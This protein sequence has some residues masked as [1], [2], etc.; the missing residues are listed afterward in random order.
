MGTK[1]NLWALGTFSLGSIWLMGANHHAFADDAV[2]QSVPITRKIG[3]PNL[4][5]RGVAHQNDT[6]PLPVSFVLSADPPDPGKDIADRPMRLAKLPGDRAASAAKSANLG[7]EMAATDESP[8]LRSP[9]AGPSLRETGRVGTTTVFDPGFWIQRTPDSVMPTEEAMQPTA[10]DVNRP[11]VDSRTGLLSQSV[12]AQQ[13]GKQVPTLNGC[14]L[15]VARQQRLPWNE[16]AAGRV[17]LQWNISPTGAVADETV[18]AV[19]PIDLHVLDCVR[20]K[21]RRWTFSRPSSGSIVHVVQPFVF[22]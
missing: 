5:N 22:R 2:A 8:R 20:S 3:P 16:V 9:F 19:D 21:M 13:L 18:V 6:V 14:R 4:Q 12:L 11:P 15:E 7:V 10:I 1:Q 17:T